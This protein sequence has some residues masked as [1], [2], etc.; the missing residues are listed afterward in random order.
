MIKFYLTLILILFATASNAQDVLNLIDAKKDLGGWTF[1]NG[2]EF[3]G[4]QGALRIAKDPFRKLPV[5]ALSGDFSEGGNYVQAQYALPDVP[6][7]TLSFWL[8][9]P[10]GAKSVGMRIIDGTEQCHQLKLK[11]NSKG[12]WQLIRIPV[13]EFFRTIG[14]SD[15]LDLTSQY[16]KWD[17]ANDGRWHQPGKLLVFLC[18]RDLGTKAELLISDVKIHPASPKTALRKTIPLD[19][20]VDQ[21]ELDWE[22]NLGQEFP[23]AKGGLVL[24]RDTPEKGVNAIRLHADFTSGGAYVGIRKSLQTLNVK[25]F[26]AI[27]LKMRSVSTTHFALRLVDGTGQCHQQKMFPIKADGKWHEVTIRP[28]SIAGGEHW[29]GANDGKWHDSVQL[30]ELM[31]NDRSSET[32]QPEL[33]LAD[34]RADVIV[35]ATRAAATF[36]DDFDDVDSLTDNWVTTGDITLSD[37]SLRLSRTLD[38]RQKETIATSKPFAVASGAWQIQYTWRSSLHSPDNSYQGSVGLQILNQAD[39]V[40]E[41]IPVGIG[42]GKHSQQSVSKT[43]RIPDGAA[44]ARFRVELK[45]TYGQFIVDAL[46][47]SRLKVQPIEQKIERVLLATEVIGNLFMPDDETKFHITVQTKQPLLDSEQVLR[48]RIR[49]YW[50]EDLLLVSDIKLVKQ[51]RRDGLYIYST[52]I[53][54]PIEQIVIGKYHELHVAIPIGSADYINDYTEYTGFAR[55]PLATAK[56]HR[57]ESIP[58]TIRNWDS[59]IP[60]YF[61]LADRLGLRTLG[62]WGGWTPQA[63]YTPECPGIDLCKSL[64]AKWITGTPAAEIER[65]GFK[66]YSEQSLRLGIKNFL[67]AYADKGLAMIAMGNEPHGTGDKVLE[68]VRAYQAIYETVKEFDPHI[69]V[70]GTSVEPNEEYFKAGYQNYLDSYDFHIYENYTD[71]RCT[72]REYRA[73]MEKYD[74]V[75][76][77]HSTELGL[78]SQGQTRLAVS[79]EMIKKI[80]SFFAEGGKT[81]SWFTIQSPDPEGKARGQSSDS[82]CMFDCKYNLYNP[83]LDAITHYHLLNSI[84]IKKFVREKHYDSGAQSYLF[85]DAD[86]QCLEVLWSDV[87]QDEITLPTSSGIQVKLIRIDGTI[88]RLVSKEGKLVVTPSEDPILLLYVD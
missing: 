44:K 42:F 35:E 85:K 14:T 2:P 43:I 81:V 26:Y 9:A 1:G 80:V 3:P 13:E 52:D 75:K 59:R 25:S 79:R 17:G 71:V 41:T 55:L 51:S 38:L 78:N 64:D 15:A 20:I 69:H 5:L 56:Q 34:I 6:V 61:H 39:A 58:F 60:D 70:L 83:R 22:F 30:I 12:G 19:A 23:G 47:A 65:N 7:D 24:Q 82:H 86:N 87:N 74:A 8:N 18:S 66:K 63:P 62:V 49:D 76:P 77:I 40:I 73:L 53:I 84:G 68:N 21:G 16:E 54:L 88:E 11:I 27:H 28:S 32:K 57:P 37:Q 46:S 72:M 29:G 45:K 48:Y 4:A 67:N 10:T 36:R 31:L 50:G 33:F